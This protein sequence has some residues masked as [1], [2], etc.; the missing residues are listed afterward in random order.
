[1][2]KGLLILSALAIGIANGQAQVAKY[3]QLS[4]AS[5]P[6][7]MMKISQD[8]NAIAPLKSKASRRAGETI[9]M[10]Y[11]YPIGAFFYGLDDESYSFSALRALTGAFDDTEF[12][13]YSRITDVD[14]NRTRITDVTWDWGTDT[15]GNPIEPIKQTIDENGS[16]IVQGY[17][18]YEFPTIKYDENTY[19]YEVVDENDQTKVYSCFWEAGTAGI[20]NYEF[21]DGNGEP[22][23][24][25]GSIGNAC[26]TFGFYGGFGGDHAFISNKTFYNLENYAETK[27]WHNT[28]KKLVGFAEY[29]AKPFGH[30]YAQSIV[31]WFWS[32][33]IADKTRP[34]NGKTITAKINTLDAENKFVEYASA[35]ATDAN[36]TFVGDNGLCYI[37]FK[38]QVEDPI[39]GTVD[40][41]IN[42]PQ[43]NFIVTLT[44]FEE[45]TGTYQAPFASTD[46]FEGFA[47][48]ILEDGSISTIGYSNDP[49][50]PQVNLYIGFRAAFPVA[51][52]S[53]SNL[54]RVLFNA[55][56]GIGAGMYD[57]EEQQLY[58]YS[59]ISTMTPAD[60]WRVVE[61]PEWITEYTFDDQYVEER[62][63]MLLELKADALP[64]NVESREGKM[65]FRVY[66][67]EMTVPVYQAKEIDPTGIKNVTINL[68]KVSGTA[69]NFAGQRVAEGYKGLIIKD[70]KKYMVK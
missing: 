31:A 33:N 69:Y 52:Y 51:N 32:D 10:M 2:K 50:T 55:E 20:A 58:G 36:V 25:N 62:G 12:T 67:K 15:A 23:V 3:S 24:H 16:A 41:P 65:V 37:E 70:G 19:K 1:M 39:F 61:Q 63:L 64:E 30:V 17:G 11:S 14:G 53:D 29:Y 40:S 60:K 44:G 28:G 54:P 7:T 57:E 26:A 27:Q 6:Q 5:Q 34:L 56:G 47:Y 18:F 49:Q 35:S 21:T 4:R 66:G 59:I 48:A 13:N 42:L 45:V 22:M 9:S 43:E 38:F 68:N 46:G 8:R